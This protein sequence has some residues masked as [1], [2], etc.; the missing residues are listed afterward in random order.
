M[1]NVKTLTKFFTDKQIKSEFFSGSYHPS[2]NRKIKLFSFF[3]EPDPKG[4]IKIISLIKKHLHKSIPQPSASQADIP[5]LSLYH[6]IQYFPSQAAWVA[7]KLREWLTAAWVAH[8][9]RE[10]LTSCVSGSQAAW[11]AQKLREWL[12]SC[13]SGSQAAWVAYKLREWLTSCVSVSQ[14]AWVAQSC[15][16]GSQAAWVAHKLSSKGISPPVCVPVCVCPIIR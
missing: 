11:A 7:H 5:P 2:K 1:F 9:L 8:K 10:R 6:Y 4:S 13:V 16:S 3:Q 15:V 12:R 14:A